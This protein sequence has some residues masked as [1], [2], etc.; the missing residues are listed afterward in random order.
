MVSVV[1]LHLADG[2]LRWLI[3]QCGRFQ[4]VCCD[5]GFVVHHVCMVGRAALENETSCSSV[6]EKT[7]LHNP[8]VP[9]EICAGLRML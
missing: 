6:I 3:M 5:I 4:R 2:V 7:S 8:R 1:R 9:V